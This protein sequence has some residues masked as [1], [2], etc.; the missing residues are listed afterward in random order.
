MRIDGKLCINCG[1]CIAYCPVNAIYQSIDF[2]EID[3]EK[4]TEC[5]T[6]IRPGI[7]ICPTKA[8]QESPSAVEY[9]RSIRRVF[10]DPAKTHKETKIPGRGTEEVKTNDVTGRVKKH[11]YGVA[12]EVGRPVVS[13][14][15][16]DFEKITMA[17]AKHKI[18]YEDRNPIKSLFLDETRGTL[19][20][21]V[22]QQRVASSII[23]FVIPCEQLESILKT[24]M[25]VSKEI[26]T[27]FSLDVIACFDSPARMPEIGCLHKLG[28][29]LRPNNKI[30][31]G[32]GRP[33]SSE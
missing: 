26:D 5:G 32:L 20:L 7:V 10:S 29:E 27:V 18:T 17:L 31:L 16:I 8:I 22:K 13:A 6:C 4:C 15:F 25:E 33:F 1:I 28:I 23:E 30:N 24:L 3:L 9:P 2:V 14:S 11:Q 21:E 19:K 12:I